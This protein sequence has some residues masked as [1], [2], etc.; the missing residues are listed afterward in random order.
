MSAPPREANTAPLTVILRGWWS[1]LPKPPSAHRD[2]VGGLLKN[3]RACR[4]CRD[5]WFFCGLQRQVPMIQ[6][7][8]RTVEIPQVQYIDKFIGA[9]PDR[10]LDVPVVM[11]QQAPT[12]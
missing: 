12:I 1:P 9:F 11:Q 8:P 10:V 7:M 3:H 5:R 4:D 2:G 6:K